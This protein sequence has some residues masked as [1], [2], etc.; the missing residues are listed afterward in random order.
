MSASKKVL[1]IV[2][3]IAIVFVVFVGIGLSVGLTYPL[4]SDTTGGD[5]SV[6][7]SITTYDWNYYTKYFTYT[8][9]A[10]NGT[11][12]ASGVKPGDTISQRADHFSVTGLTD[13]TLLPD[14]VFPTTVTYKVSGSTYTDAITEI[15]STLYGEI[16]YKSVP[17]HIYISPSIT[18]V[19]QNAFAGLTNLQTVTIC[20]S[21]TTDTHGIR[22]GYNAFGDCTALSTIKCEGQLSIVFTDLSCAGC[23]S[24]ATLSKGT[25]NL[26]YIS[27]IDSTS[28]TTPIT[29]SNWTSGA[30]YKSKIFPG[31]PSGLNPFA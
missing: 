27:N 22:F 6:A 20:A 1:K 29:S 30:N 14:I 13:E 18:K 11:V 28:S 15:G 5:T 7:P 21:S 10:A 31:T 25:C 4:W 9:Y 8:A 16:T 2:L 17:T 12:I 19:R 24:L 3:P 23:S 26:F